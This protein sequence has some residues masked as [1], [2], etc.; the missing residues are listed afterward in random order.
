MAAKN[1]ET[2]RTTKMKDSRDAYQAAYIRFRTVLDSM[3][4]ITLRYSLNDPD[5]QERMRRMSDIEV[6]VMKIV[7]K[8][9]KK[10]RSEKIQ[11]PEPSGECPDGFINC[12]GCCVPY[13]CPEYRD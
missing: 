7:K 13:Q 4:A 10:L 2:A 5:P 11:S 3:E 8:Y 1:N 12:G 6:D 9:E